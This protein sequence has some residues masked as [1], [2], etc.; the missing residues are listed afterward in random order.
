MERFNMLLIAVLGKQENPSLEKL[1]KTILKDHNIKYNITLKYTE[2]YN[3][4]YIETLKQSGISVSII[5]LSLDEFDSIKGIMFDVILYDNILRKTEITKSLLKNIHSNTIIIAN[6]DDMNAFE[7]L[8]EIKICI[9]TYGLNMRSTVTASSIEQ[10]ESLFNFVYC[11]QRQ[12]STF[13]ND[14][15]EPEEIPVTI[16]DKNV[17]IYNALSCVTT[18][19]LLGIPTEEITKINLQK[20]F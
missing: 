12:I 14:I 11:L 2:K 18:A 13:N 17:N 7:F 4:D 16:I 20:G 6:S 3:I 15:I 1:L 19:L 5:F 10:G 9:I 8:S